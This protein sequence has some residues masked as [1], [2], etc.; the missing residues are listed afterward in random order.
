MGEETETQ[1][2]RDKDENLKPSIF[3]ALPAYALA[4]TKRS[5]GFGPTSLCRRLVVSSRSALLALGM[6]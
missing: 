2:K 3:A 5:I 6:M 1:V 4:E